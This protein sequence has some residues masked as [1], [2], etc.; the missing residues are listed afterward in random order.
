MHGLLGLALGGSLG[1]EDLLPRWLG[2]WQL[3]VGVNGLNVAGW[4]EVE[5]RAGKDG[6]Y[7]ECPHGL[8]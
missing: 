6:Q 7:D 4:T 8:V 5:V 3:S 1:L 2:I